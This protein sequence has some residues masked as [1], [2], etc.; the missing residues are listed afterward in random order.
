MFTAIKRKSTPITSNGSTF[1]CGMK[2]RILRCMHCVS[3]VD[4]LFCP[5]VLRLLT[6][7]R[8]L[9]FSL[10]ATPLHGVTNVVLFLQVQLS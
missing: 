10:P 3:H 7:D 4:I 8:V 9:S 5:V 1:V 2:S 6:L